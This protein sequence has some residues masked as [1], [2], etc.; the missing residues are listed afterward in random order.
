MTEERVTKAILQ[1]LEKNRWNIVCFDFP[2]SGTGVLLHPN[3][4]IR[5]SKN[6]GAIMPDIVAIKGTM[7]IIMENKDRFVL[8]DFNKIQDLRLGD[9]YSESIS[10]LLEAYNYS[11][12]FYGAGLPSTKNTESKIEDYKDKIDFAIFVKLDGQVIIQYQATSIFS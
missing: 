11:Q 12:I 8:D 10:K 3:K 5:T 1:W 2:Q 6:K 9:D 4:K 7:V